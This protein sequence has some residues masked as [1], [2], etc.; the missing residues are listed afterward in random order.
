MCMYVF[1]RIM[2]KKQRVTVDRKPLTLES[3]KAMS[4]LD[5]NM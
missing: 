1:G 5:D 3:C 4:K 2:S